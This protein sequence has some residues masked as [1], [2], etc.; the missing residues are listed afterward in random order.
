MGRGFGLYG[1]ISAVGCLA[2][3]FELKVILTPIEIDRRKF[4]VTGANR[5]VF[6]PDFMRGRDTPPP[7]GQTH[8]E[9]KSNREAQNAETYTPNGLGTMVVLGIERWLLP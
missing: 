3:D 7:K 8:H 9:Y 4:D 2:H 5:F 6:R 1:E